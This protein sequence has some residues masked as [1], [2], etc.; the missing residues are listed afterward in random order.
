MVVLFPHDET[1]PAVVTEQGVL[2]SSSMETS[3]DVFEQE[4]GRLVGIAYGLLGSYSE[5]EDVVQE[6]WLRYHGSAQEVREPEAWLTTVVTRIAIDRL[7]SAQKRRESYPG[8]WLPEPVSHLP[9]SETTQINRSMLSIGFLHLLEKLSPEERAVMVLREAFDRSHEEIGTILGKS[10]AACRQ[11]LSRARKQL[12]QE[13]ADRLGPVPRNVVQQCIDA[14]MQGDEERLL[15][16]LANDAIL[17]GD[18]G[19]RVPS[20]LNPIYGAERIVRFFF[21]LLRKFPNHYRASLT[22]VNSKPAMLILSGDR[23][24]VM[25]MS[26]E[27]GRITAL[28][29]V[30]NPEKLS[31]VK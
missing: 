15:G 22:T 14:L 27:G 19:G 4:R 2:G 25:A 12:R 8:V 7:R 13:R 17:Y 21:G 18:G 24:S 9:S 6:V 5:A 30:S 10:A 20:V 3:P 29:L 11:L 26:F 31:A 16:L 23:R 1:A 28:H